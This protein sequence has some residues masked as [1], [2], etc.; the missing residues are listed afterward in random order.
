[1]DVDGLALGFSKTVYSLYYPRV[2]A[3]IDKLSKDFPHDLYKEAW[4]KKQDTLHEE[5]LDT[6]KNWAK[7]FIPD[8]HWGK[9]FPHSYPTNGSSEAIRETLAQYAA[10]C[11][12]QEVHPVIH[13]FIGE[14]EGYKAIAEGYNIEVRRLL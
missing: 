11:A 3:V 9:E 6:W 4:T 14:Y 8:V 7:P 13:T 10:D 12:I 1:M 2:Q 5:F